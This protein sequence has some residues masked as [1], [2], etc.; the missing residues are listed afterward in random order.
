MPRFALLVVLA[1]A[2]SVL[3]VPAGAPP[4]DCFEIRVVDEQTGRGV[5]LVEL[6]TVHHLL[7]VTDS[8]GMVAFREPALMNREVFFHVRSHGYEFP[9][10]GFGY[11][12]TRFLTRP[13]GAVE[14]KIRR[15]NLAERLYRITGEGI[16]RDSV[17]LGDR[18]PIA[19]PLL[20][21]QVAGQ[22][23]VMAVPYR[24]RIY[25]FWGDTLRPKYP[26]GHFRT[27]GA[28]SDLPAQGGLA[29]STG[30]DLS[31]FTAP[32]GFSRP[33][34]DAEGPGPIWLEGVLTIL[35]PSGA[36]RL[37][38]HYSRMK[39]LGTVLEHGL[40]AWNDETGCFDKLVEF[41]LADQIRRPHGHPVRHREAGGEFFYFPKPFPTVRVR[42]EWASLID[43]ASYE[44]FSAEAKPD[45]TL[46]WSWRAGGNPTGQAE[47]RALIR[48]GKPAPDKARWQLADADSGKPVE[49]HA[50]SI[51]W[52]G[53][54]KRWVMIA[55]EKGGTSHLG[56][57]WYAEAEALTGPW[58][59]SKK[60]ISHDR[61]SFY[62]PEQHPFFAE[63]DGRVIYFE[64]TYTSMFSG[65][66]SP[67]P[68]YDYNQIMYRLD[69]SDPRLNLTASPSQP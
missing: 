57:V 1:L 23:S 26:L 34:I 22:D 51:A 41:P 33:L 9:K 29:P 10:D 63:E 40:V 4:D 39:D 30:V 53:Y 50:S 25:W 12:G 66:P 18:P 54:R 7:F 42:A 58:R 16:Y 61:Y 48:A 44:S 67:T 6:E 36:E 60:V 11:A 68:R 24:G 49:A 13:G 38:G 28:T 65:N 52:N 37:L 3:P 35:D 15:L 20:N 56:E 62:N 69:L 59:R 17:L 27:A 21:A 64:G 55:T 5:P 8:A 45:G 43:Q 46:A 31:Y 2:A 32:D 19:E 14:L 47:E